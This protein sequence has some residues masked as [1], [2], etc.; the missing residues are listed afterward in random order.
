M[1]A[2]VVTLILCSVRSDIAKAVMII[3]IADTLLG[4][5]SEEGW[6][7]LIELVGIG[8]CLFLMDAS[9]YDGNVAPWH[10]HAFGFQI[11]LLNFNQ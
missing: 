8:A 7:G 3:L 10:D 6:T 11:A 4:Y 5:H 2:E 9:C 1:T